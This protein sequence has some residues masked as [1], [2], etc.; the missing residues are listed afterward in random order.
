MLARLAHDLELEWPVAEGRVDIVDGKAT[1]Q[2][3]LDAGAVTV[4]GARKNGVLD[5]EVLSAGDR[6]DIKK[7][8]L[9]SIGGE[10]RDAAIRAEVTMA[11]ADASSGA[12]ATGM[13]PARVR[14]ELPCGTSTTDAQIRVTHTD[15]VTHANGTLTLSL[16][17]LG[18]PEIKGPLGAF[19]LK[20]KIELTFTAELS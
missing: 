19:R 15:G 12:P 17:A 11:Y 4:I 13:L 9:S 18:V 7:K 16:R 1:A 5:R 2:M 20:D 10:P 14:V 8:L 6:A 3:R